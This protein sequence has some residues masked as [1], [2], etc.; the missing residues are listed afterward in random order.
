MHVPQ[1]TKR[2]FAVAL[3]LLGTAGCASALPCARVILDPDV[4]IE[5]KVDELV[6]TA[7]IAYY[8]EEPTKGYQRVVHNLAH[9][10]DQCGLRKNQKLA[11]Q[12]AE[13]FDYVKLLSLSLQNDH[14]LGFDV[15][16][17]VYFA[18]TSHLTIIPDFLRTPR[19]LRAVS[20]FESL[21]TAKSLLRE[22]N[23][24]RSPSN[25]LLFFSFSSRHLGTPDNPDSYRRLLIIVPG[26]AEEYAPEKWVQFG[27]ADPGKPRTV[28]NI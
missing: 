5:G 22:L 11:S 9:T 26:N 10:I 25:Q 14:E 13:L 20:S 27:I 17:A 23:A 12:Y 4:W 16:D 1:I 28:R 19:F 18:E 24:Q 8:G 15:T 7:R 2:V 21:G 6:S 3:V